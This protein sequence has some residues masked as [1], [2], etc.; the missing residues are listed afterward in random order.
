MAEHNQ[1]DQQS[2][3]EFVEWARDDRLRQSIRFEIEDLP[4]IDDGEYRLSRQFGERFDVKT[5]AGDNLNLG[6]LFQFHTNGGIEAGVPSYFEFKIESAVGYAS[7]IFP[8]HRAPP[9]VVPPVLYRGSRLRIRSGVN[10]NEDWVTLPAITSI[11]CFTASRT[12]RNT[13]EAYSSILMI[14]YQDPMALP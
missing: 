4:V 13:G 7:T 1:P 5:V 12:A 6:D 14:W 11:G 10:H 8:N 3:I 9:F 2:Q